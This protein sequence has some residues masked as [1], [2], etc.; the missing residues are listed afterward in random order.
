MAKADSVLHT[1][2]VK[3]VSEKNKSLCIDD[4][5]YEIINAEKQ[6]FSSVKKG[7]EISFK[8]KKSKNDKGYDCMK[9]VTPITI[10]K[11][12]EPKKEWNGN[13]GGFN[14]GGGKWQPKAPEE[15]TSIVRQ[16]CIKAAVELISSISTAKT[17]AE[18]ATE[19]VLE[20]AKAWAEWCDVKKNSKPFSKQE[21]KIEEDVIEDIEDEVEDE[22]ED[23]PPFDTE[24]DEV[25]DTPY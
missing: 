4:K 6:N 17:S 23:E 16:T 21:E 7:A 10:L 14:K 9:I 1:G 12:P 20:M 11:E 8:W 13:K 3:S 2:K 22:L 24:E 15:Q 25:D 18:K 19:Q 5:W